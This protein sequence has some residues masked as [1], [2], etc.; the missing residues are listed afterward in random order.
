[1]NPNPYEPPRKINP[2]QPRQK[3]SWLGIWLL[4]YPVF[5]VAGFFLG[6]ILL[7]PPLASLDDSGGL[8][9]A[10]GSVLGLLIYGLFFDRN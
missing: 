3:K 7:T 10:I 6:G 2:E 5:I 1:M 9:C 4:G 8:Q